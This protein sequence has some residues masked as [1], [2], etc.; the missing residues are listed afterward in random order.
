MRDPIKVYSGDRI[1]DIANLTPEDVNVDEI[2]LAL[3][4]IC[5]YNGHLKSFYSVAEHSLYVSEYVEQR[6]KEISMG[7][8]M[9]REYA[10]SA[11]LHDAA[12]AYIGD[13]VY[14]LKNSGMFDGY[15]ELEAE[16]EAVIA[17]AFDLTIPISRSLIKDT[18]SG[19]TTW[20]KVIF[21]Q[22]T[23]REAPKP[24]DV[25]RAFTERFHDLTQNL[26]RTW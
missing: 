16:I 19:I 1:I 17:K 8:E 2:A 25:T 22:F 6:A 4:H 23:L 10:L 14:P 13:I 15:I 24:K 3:A 12:E 7:E 18:D 5:R 11:L 21:R 26:F 9:V 20:E